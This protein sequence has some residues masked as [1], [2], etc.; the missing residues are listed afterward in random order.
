[1]RHD[2]VE[3]ADGFDA[4][5]VHWGGSPQAYNFCFLQMAWMNLMVLAT[6]AHIFP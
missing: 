4:V 2:F 1:M 3:I 5:L 6:K